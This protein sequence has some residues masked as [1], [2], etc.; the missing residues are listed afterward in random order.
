MLI[1]ASVN[2]FLGSGTGLPVDIVLA[3]ALWHMSLV[4][5]K[6]RRLFMVHRSPEGETTMYSAPKPERCSLVGLYGF[7]ASISPF[8][9][10]CFLFA[11]ASTNFSFHVIFRPDKD[12]L[13]FDRVSSVTFL[14][15]FPL[16]DAEILR[17]VF[18]EA[19]SRFCLCMTSL[20]SCSSLLV[21][22]NLKPSGSGE[23]GRMYLLVFPFVMHFR[24][25]VKER[26]LT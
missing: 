12:W 22:P 23:P 2:L 19:G 8:L 7:G 17:L 26:F 3:R 21:I 4:S 14:P 5:A 9:I 1:L 18:S 11:W 24:P 13:S 6:R 15:V 10:F 16:L 25:L 20:A